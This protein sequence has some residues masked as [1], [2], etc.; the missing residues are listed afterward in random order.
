M[1]NRQLVVCLRSQNVPVRLTINKKR[2]VSETATYVSPQFEF[3]EAELL[4]LLTSD[5]FLGAHGFSR[6]HALDVFVPNT[7][8][9]WWNSTAEE[10]Y[11][12][13]KKEYDKF[14]TGERL[15]KAARLDL[16]PQQVTTLASIVEEETNVEDEKPVVAGV[17]LN[18]LRKNMLLQA[19]PTVKYALKDFGLRRILNRHLEVE[20]PYNTYK[21]VGLPPGPI[22]IPSIA[23]IDAVLSPEQHEYLYMCASADFSGRH[24]FAKTLAQHNQNAAA[25]Q[26]ELNRRGIR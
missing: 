2:L 8:H 1:S 15:E 20:S 21:Y 16:T 11:L 22:C 10:L 19:D 4:Q 18:R 25:Y 9:I 3:E 24:A 17:Y 26:A 6:P 23:S 14:W 12:R 7:Y 5:S 13:L